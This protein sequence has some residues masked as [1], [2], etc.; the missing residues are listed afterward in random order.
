MFHTTPTLGPTGIQPLS[1]YPTALSL[2]PTPASIPTARLGETL[3]TPLPLLPLPVV[4]RSSQPFLHP[5]YLFIYKYICLFMYKYI[6]FY[7]YKYTYIFIV[8]PQAKHLV[9][10][11]SVLRKSTPSMTLLWKTSFVA[12]LP[13]RLARR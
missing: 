7:V 13:T 3:L 4:V 8:S 1:R 2:T 9:I 11:P 12:G 6:Y 10:W 5:R